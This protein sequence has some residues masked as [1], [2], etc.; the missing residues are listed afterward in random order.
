MRIYPVVTVLFRESVQPYTFNGTNISIPTKTKVWLP[1][2]SIQ[3]D[4]KLFPNPEVF[5]PEN[6]REEVKKNRHPMAHL[7]FGDGPRNCI[8]IFSFQ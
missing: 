4:P 3:R 7:P 2:Y 6:F 5:D 8:G 1:I